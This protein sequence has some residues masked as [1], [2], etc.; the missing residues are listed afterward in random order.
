MGFTAEPRESTGPPPSFT[1]PCSFFSTL[2]W[3]VAVVT[4][5]TIATSGSRPTAAVRAPPPVQAISSCAVATAYAAALGLRAL[6]FLSASSTTYAPIRL[7]MLRDAMRRLGSVSAEQA[8]TAGS[9]T[10][11]RLRAS[12]LF[13]APMSIHMELSLVTWSRSSELSRCTDFFPITPST[14][15]FFP[16]ITTRWPTST[17]AS[18]PPMVEK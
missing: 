11:T 8:T 16:T 18:Q 13:L 1:S 12:C 17:C 6:S 15:P 2:G 5:T 4:S 3:S 7:S 14:G 10:R 9:P